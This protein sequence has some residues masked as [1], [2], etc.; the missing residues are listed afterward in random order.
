MIKVSSPMMI[1]SA[2]LCV[3][4]W[5]C[6]H[7]SSQHSA[8]NRTNRLWDMMGIK[9]FIN[10]IYYYFFFIQNSSCQKRLYIRRNVLNDCM[11]NAIFLLVSKI[12]RI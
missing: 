9:Y 8:V 11:H 4:S 3:L 2:G 1:G 5:V 6:E 12:V 7:Y 10:F